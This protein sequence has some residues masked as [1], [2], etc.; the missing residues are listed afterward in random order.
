MQFDKFNG[1]IYPENHHYNNQDPE[2]FHCLYNILYDT[3]SPFTPDPR[4]TLSLSPACRYSVEY[5]SSMNKYKHKQTNKYKH[6]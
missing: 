3:S 5:L 6:K 1:C 2:Y 4:E